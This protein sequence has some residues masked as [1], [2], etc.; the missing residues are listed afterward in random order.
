LAS[1]SWTEQ[2]LEDLDGICHFIARDSLTAAKSFSRR[3]FET[4]DRLEENPQLG[5]MVPELGK[6]ELREIL[7]GRFRV[8]YRFEV[9]ENTID[10]LTVC[11][12][13]QRLDVSSL[14]TDW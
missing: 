14:E 10:V 5:R 13:A 4:T 2:A 9:D 6:T 12:G 7:F 11:H 8:I 3:I 1:V